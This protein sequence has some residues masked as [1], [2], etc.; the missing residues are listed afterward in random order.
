LPQS[1]TREGAALLV[2]DT[3]DQYNQITS[4]IEAARIVTSMED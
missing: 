4:G 1:I 2:H 3:P